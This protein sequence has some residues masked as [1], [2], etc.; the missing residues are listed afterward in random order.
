MEYVTK[1]ACKLLGNCR[2]TDLCKELE[3]GVQQKDMATLEANNV[4]LEGLV[5]D[6]KG[7]IAK[8]DKEIKW[9]NTQSKEG[10]DWIRKFIGNSGNM[11]NKARLFD[12]EVKTEG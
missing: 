6:L 3:K 11:V 1:G 5:V 12:N 4:K 10:L 8:K 9:L 7:E 2:P